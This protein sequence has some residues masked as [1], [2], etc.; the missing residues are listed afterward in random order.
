[1]LLGLCDR[2]GMRRQTMHRLLEEVDVALEVLGYLLAV[3]AIVG[4]VQA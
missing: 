4:F 3:F 2:L 1:M